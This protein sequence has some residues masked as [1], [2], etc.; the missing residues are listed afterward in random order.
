MA[1]SGR[2]IAGGGIAVALASEAIASAVGMTITLKPQTSI[3]AMLFS[4]GGARAVYA[5]P[6]NK[7]IEFE[8]IWSGYEHCC[9]GT[10]GGNMFKWENEISV[11][12]TKLTSAFMEGQN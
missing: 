1:D 11:P 10:A 4:E 2:A 3:E 5:I 9:I 6:E 7:A 12:L 8:N